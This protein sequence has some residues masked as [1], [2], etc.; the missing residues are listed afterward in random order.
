MMTMKLRLPHLAA[1]CAPMLLASLA[2]QAQNAPRY[3]MTA[4]GL[5]SGATH[6]AAFS[7]DANGTA[8]G[9]VNTVSTYTSLC[10]GSSG[11]DIV[12]LFP[13][14]CKLTRDI[15]REATWPISTASVQAPTLGTAEFVPV[16]ASGDGTLVGTK[17]QYQATETTYW[18]PVQ[19]FRTGNDS[20]R[21]FES[22]TPWRLM[23][24]TNDRGAGIGTKYK[25]LVFKKG[26]SVSN[27]PFAP[28][29]GLQSSLTGYYYTQVRG[30]SS[31][32]VALVNAYTYEAGTTVPYLFDGVRYTKLNDN[33]AKSRLMGTAM[34]GQGAVAGIRFVAAAEGDT[35]P[36]VV[37]IRWVNGSAVALGGSELKGYM[38]EAMNNNGQIL[39]HR[40]NYSGPVVH[41]AA[42]WS[43]GAL[44]PIPAPQDGASQPLPDGRSYGLIPVAINSRGD[45]AGCG[46]FPFVWRDG[47]LNNL[48]QALTANGQTTPN[49]KPLDCVSAINDQ[50][51]VLANYPLLQSGTYE[52]YVGWVRLTPLP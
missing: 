3:G 10:G 39:L 30:L 11:I 52:N 45:V 7:L 15:A 19:L 40:I 44:T 1:L 37:P 25:S 9:S 32:N 27:I 12:D 38:P 16:G 5:P 42:V 20:H 17:G 33:L 26:S 51:M 41:E 13:R 23:V 28:S 47:V 24:Q 34:N 36:P 2:A 46:A 21:Y 48:N 14:L 22:T 50:G 4:L 29:T 35:S 31:K 8:H 49:G 43:N 6:S 18:N